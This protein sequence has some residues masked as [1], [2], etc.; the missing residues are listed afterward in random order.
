MKTMMTKCPTC[1]GA[2]V[3]ETDASIG[4]RLRNRRVARKVS[5]RQLAYQMQISPPY[6]SDLELGRRGWST[7]LQRR[8]EDALSNK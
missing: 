7:G 1:Q 3:I 2:G 8:Y 5:L 4:Q 6:L